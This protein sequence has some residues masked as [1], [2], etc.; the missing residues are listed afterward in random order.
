MRRQSVRQFRIRRVGAGTASFAASADSIE[1]AVATEEPLEIRLAYTAPGG[2][3]RESSISVTMRTPGKDLELA[4]GFL[5]T[6]GIIRGSGDVDSVGPCGPPA[7]NGLVNVVKVELAPSVDVDLDRL[8]R[9]FYTSSSC[10]VCGKSSLE[11]VAVQGRYDLHSVDGV[12]SRD[13]L[14]GLP[15][16]LRSQ[17]DVFD[18]TGGLHASGLFDPNGRIVLVREDVGRHNALDKLIGNRL[19]AD[20]LPLSRFGI[21]VSGRASFELMQKAMMA[22]CPLV[23]AVGAPSSLA[24]ELAEEFGMT[25]IG[26]LKKD[27]FN[28]YSRPDRVS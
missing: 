16:A 21:V 3:R 4:V 18:R 1:D 12:F 11:A 2:E 5:Y 9:H 10:G 17:Q 27:R 8:E 6:E 15:D 19:M 25:L 26:F 14:G 28:I 7:A 20:K 23:A 24:V 13:A 22:G